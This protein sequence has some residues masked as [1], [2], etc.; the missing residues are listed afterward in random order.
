MNQ[1]IDI[2]NNSLHLNKDYENLFSAIKERLGVVDIY[3]PRL[4]GPVYPGHPF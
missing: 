1:G 2:R 3:S 4:L